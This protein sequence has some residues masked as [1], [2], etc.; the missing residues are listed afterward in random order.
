[1]RQL[2]ALWANDL[3]NTLRDRTVGVL[4][5]IPLVFALGLRFGL[6]PAEAQFPLLADHRTLV[7]ALFCLLASAFPGLMLA[8][9]LLEERD[10]GLFP[11]FRTLPISPSGFLLGRLALATGLSFLYPLIILATVQGIAPRPGW[12]IPLLA[13]LCSLQAPLSVLLVV[14]L[15]SNKIEGLAVIKAL[16]PAILLP[17]APFALTAPWAHLLAILPAYWIYRAFAGGG[18]AAVG[19]AAIGALLFHLVPSALLLRRFQRRD[20]L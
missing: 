5:F 10:E 3:R 17:A 1:M 7:I 13:L 12:R 18:P 11:V 14:V 2:T 4:L 16:F 8:F 20:F 6:G 15:A 19:F 9:I